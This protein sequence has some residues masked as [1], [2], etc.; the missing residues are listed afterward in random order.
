MVLDFIRIFFVNDAATTEIYTYWYTR[1]LHAALPLSRLA[2]YAGWRGAVTGTSAVERAEITVDVIVLIPGPD[3][4]T[5]PP[6][7]PYKDRIKPGDLSPEI[8][9]AHV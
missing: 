8:G 5:A 4:I 3:A 2:C 6:W 9:R 7:V 1:P